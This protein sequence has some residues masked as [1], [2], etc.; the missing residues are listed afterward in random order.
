MKNFIVLF[1]LCFVTGGLYA[2]RP[3]IDSTA[4]NCWKRIDSYSISDNGLWVKYRYVYVNSGKQKDNIQNRYY[5]Y[6]EQTGKT[7]VLDNIEYPEFFG[8]GSWIYYTDIASSKACLMNLVNGRK[9]VWDRA[10]EPNCDSKALLV[11]YKSGE[12]RVF[13]QPNT[14][15]SVVYEQLNAYK[16]LNDGRNILYVYEGVNEHE[17][18]YGELFNP[19]KYKVIYRDAEKLL[20]RFDYYNGRGSFKLEFPD[21]KGGSFQYWQFDLEGTVKMVADTRSWN[22][23]EDL[24]DKISSIHLLGKGVVW[25][26]DIYTNGKPQKKSVKKASK[27]MPFTLELWSWNDPVIQSEQEKRGYREPRL[28]PDKYIYD[29]RTG[30]LT[31]ICSGNLT[32]IRFQPTDVPQYVLLSDNSAFEKR[33]D[34]QYSERRAWFLANLKTGEIKEFTNEQT[35]S[36]VWT[37]DGKYVVY[38]D[39]ITKAWY[40]LNPENFQ[41]DNV[42][43]KIGYPIY[44]EL[45]DKPLPAEPYG[46]SGWSEDG[47]YAY[48]YD[49]FDIWRIDMHDLSTP[50]CITKGVGRKEGIVLRFLNINYSDYLKIDESKPIYLSLLEWKTRNQGIGRVLADGK[51]QKDLFGPFMLQ[52]AGIS[53]DGRKVIFSRQSFTEGRNVWIYDLRT[54]KMKCVSDANP[55]HN[56]YQWGT[57]KMVEWTNG[58]GKVNQGLLYLPYNYDSSKKYPVIVDYYETH[59]EE[60]HMYQVPGWSSALL[61]IPTFLSHD[62]V[63]FRPDVYFTIGDPAKSV[64]DAIVSGVEYLIQE[65]VAD[66]ERIGLQGHSWSGCTASQLIT[67]TDIFK[68]ANINAGVVNMIEAYT[69]L[70]IGTGSTRMFMYEDWQCRMGKN[71]WE[72]K[73]AY[74]LNSSILNV[75]KIKTPVLIMH[76]DQDEAVEYHEGRNLF[77][78]L[79]RLQKPVWL[80]NYKGEGHFI[81]NEEAQKDWSIRMM[82]FFDY[83]LKGGDTPRWMVEGININERGLDPKYDLLK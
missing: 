40:R 7:R 17:L 16:L 44:N 71:L 47:R 54:H 3:K 74:I 14:D 56:G 38:Y 39:D 82:Q 61:N 77:L 31:K 18:R 64:Y 26:L 12:N 28:K 55:D 21:K 42:S 32:S 53:K 65:G 4:Y 66:S 8:G 62:Y 20:K 10:G 15:D 30:Q 13:W 51:L 25:D 46:L 52:A 5:F 37:P 43:E 41:V 78:A 57:V 35:Q 70:R 59:A 11:N 79:R 58:A 50:Y 49:R 1:V 36:A 48:I 80:L 27:E 23:P 73:D 68:C 2:S 19:Q 76:N 72:A 63:I 6:N 75:D 67:M 22:L 9:I 60:I 24:K 45:N 81:G 69:A 83:Y 33:K 29:T 34:W